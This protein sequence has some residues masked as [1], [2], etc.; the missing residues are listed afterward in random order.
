MKKGEAKHQ[1]CTFSSAHAR[2]SRLMQFIRNYRD[3]RELKALYFKAAKL[4][5]SFI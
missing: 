4:F 2:A 1:T 3:Q 5:F